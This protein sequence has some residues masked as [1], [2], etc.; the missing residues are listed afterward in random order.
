VQFDPVFEGNSAIML[1]GLRTTS[2]LVTRVPVVPT[3]A[4][5]ALQ[6]RQAQKEARKVVRQQRRAEKAPLARPSSSAD[7]LA[8]LPDLVPDRATVAPV[9]AAALAAADAA[10]AARKALVLP[11]RSKRGYGSK[12]ARQ[13]AWAL[14]SADALIPLLPPEAVATLSGGEEGRRQVADP[15]DRAARLRTTVLVQAGR[16]GSI[17]QGAARTLVYIR[18]FVKSYAAATGSSPEPFP[19][20]SDRAALIIAAEHHRATRDAKGSRGGQTVA[21]GLRTSMAVCADDI[22]CPIALRCASVAAAAPKATA[23]GGRATVAATPPLKLLL[24]LVALAAEG[25]SSVVRFMA[26]SL[27]IAIL[28]GVRV[29]DGLSI[30]LWLDPVDPDGII[31]GRAEWKD[32]EPIDLF[33]P[34]VCFGITL[35]WLREHVGACIALGQVFPQWSGPRGSRSDLRKATSL[36]PEVAGED[37]ARTALFFLWELPPLRLTPAQRRALGVRGHSIH[38]AL[39]DVAR[40][41]GRFPSVPFPLSSDL[42]RGFDKED[43]RVYGH[44]LRDPHEVEDTGPA[45][46]GDGTARP[47]GAAQE[48]SDQSEGYT[49]GA[50]RTGEREEQLTARTRLHTYIAAAIAHDGREWTEWPSGRADLELLKPGARVE[51]PDGPQTAD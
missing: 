4:T 6:R 38:L 23:R 15:I 25:T 17:L 2:D 37:D 20:S 46:N 9:S 42:R 14:A 40:F 32:G 22:G 35:A 48:R 3:A 19:V 49:R 28:N 11:P 50:G 5:T 21:H 47:P 13:E 7:P 44:W 16:D 1:R 43:R 33:A 27:L 26:R 51:L 39:S 34:A 18:A 31:R 12:K 29:S 10:C 36:L 24:Q 45:R 30:T 41:I 8:D